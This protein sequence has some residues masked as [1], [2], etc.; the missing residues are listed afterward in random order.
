MSV[1]PRGS[2]FTTNYKQRIQTCFATSC[3]NKVR[4]FQCMMITLVETTEYDKIGSVN[5]LPFFWG[6]TIQ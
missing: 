5:T 6:Y 3:E 4:I 1:V 2:T